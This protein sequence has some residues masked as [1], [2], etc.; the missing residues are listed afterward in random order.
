MQ[1]LF[2]LFTAP[3]GYS[4]ETFCVEHARDIIKV[5]TTKQPSDV[6]YLLAKRTESRTI[7]DIDISSELEP[8][9]AHK[10]QLVNKDS[11]SASHANSHS[12]KAIIYLAGN[13]PF[14]MD[15]LPSMEPFLQTV[16]QIMKETKMEDNVACFFQHYRGH[17]A[18]QSHGQENFN[19]YSIFQDAKDQALLVKKLVEEGY[20]PDD[21]ILMGYSYGSA[22]ALWT[23]YYLVTEFDMKYINVKFYSDRGYGDPFDFPYIKPFIQDQKEA[24][25][26][27]Y[28]KEMM[29]FVQL[30]DLAAW[31][32]DTFVFRIHNDRS[33]W[34]DFSLA[35]TFKPDELPGRVWIG[36]SENESTQDPHYASRDAIGLKTI[37]EI[38]PHHFMAAMLNEKPIDLYFDIK[39]P[40]LN[41]HSFAGY[42]FKNDAAMGSA[43]FVAL[44]VIEMKKDNK[45]EVKEVFSVLSNA[46]SNLIQ[47]LHGYC[48]QRAEQAAASGYGGDYKKP[49]LGKSGF[50]GWTAKE[51]VQMAV[52]I[53]TSLCH[54]NGPDIT[55]LRSIQQE[56][57]P[58]CSG[59]LFKIF[60]DVMSFVEEYSQLQHFNQWV[61]TMS[62][63]RQERMKSDYAA[64]KIALAKLHESLA[65][66]WVLLKT[67]DQSQLVP[68]M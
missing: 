4:I 67:E 7:E 15:S 34:M 22:V 21:I 36:K 50:V 45:Q 55:N 27:L 31:L 41:G 33:I 20:K 42:A 56:D 30:H 63:R 17:G 47:Q 48:C 1:R 16:S 64:E 62:F 59:G 18:N 5:R 58:H 3:I 9:I 25:Q 65:D 43:D 24:H 32:P 28:E 54:E 37:Q 6:W 26:R 8:L 66:D 2:G 40:M 35:N 46:I 49:W 44:P 51:Q 12:K 53:M 52:R 39:I 57:G 11:A 68:H 13:N 60:M 29:P 10:L 38:K 19:D 61:T 14:I 23:I